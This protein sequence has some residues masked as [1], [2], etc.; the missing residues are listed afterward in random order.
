MNG[1]DLKEWLSLRARLEPPQLAPGQRGKLILE[2][3][4][5]DDCHIEAHVPSEP[6]LVPTE[7]SFDPVEDLA[8]GPV[9]YPSGDEER[10]DWSPVSLRVYRGTIRLE[11]PLELAAEAVTGSRRIR[12]RVRYQ[13]CT[14]SS[15]LMPSAQPV[16]VV[17][18][19]G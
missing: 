11:A 10:F 9:D 6:F 17:L 14:P 19:V 8:I 7:L 15:C 5:P 18:D 16:E 4:I 13:G 3:G 12:G 1:T 2:I